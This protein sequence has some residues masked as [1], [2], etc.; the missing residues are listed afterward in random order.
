MMVSA[1]GRLEAIAAGVYFPRRASHNT[2][3]NEQ[4]IKNKSLEAICSLFSVPC[5][6]TKGN[7]FERRTVAKSAGQRW[8]RLAA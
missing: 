7:R 6:D 3:N 4:R 8:H 2:K 1:I 5:S